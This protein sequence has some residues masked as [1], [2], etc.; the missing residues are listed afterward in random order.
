MPPAYLL[1]SHGSSDKR[2]QAGL[3]NL[4]SMVRHCLEQ[5]RR[6]ERLRRSPHSPEVMTR[7][8]TYQGYRHPLSQKNAAI[9]ALAYGDA[10]ISRPVPP[11]VGTATLE[12]APISLAEQ[13]EIFARRVMAQGVRHLVI[14]PV[15]LLAGVH[16]KED[17]PREIQQ[18]KESLPDRI[19][20]TC[21]P[22]LGSDVGFKQFV[23]NRLKTVSAERCLLIA[24]GSKRSGGNRSVQ[25][26]STLLNAELAFW[27]VPPDLEGQVL[28][29]IA[30]GYQSLAIAPFFL[31]PGD[32]TDAITHR[33][34]AI[35][36][37]FPTV[38]FRL[39]SPL[40][41]S[42]DL[43]KVVAKLALE[44]LPGPQNVPWETDLA[45]LGRVIN[46]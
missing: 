13:I 34:E 17:L 12:G 11:L 46:Q 26:L 3:A 40:G 42:A 1:V 33:T 5:P 35:A 18:A 10:R 22:Y 24:H 41:T 4:A 39:L 45:S 21:T 37:Q 16:V 8:A 6:G 28:N 9:S 30:E 19:C 31:F 29:L 23:A 38:S 32:I 36:E 27:S 2:H 44:S 7:L 25:Q 20:I 15:F 43:G 14:V